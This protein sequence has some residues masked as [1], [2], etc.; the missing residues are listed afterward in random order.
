MHHEHLPARQP[1]HQ[2]AGGSGQASSASAAREKGDD[3][4]LIEETGRARNDR[5]QYIEKAGQHFA[6]Q[7]TYKER[8]YHEGNQRSTRISKYQR[9]PE[10]SHLQEPTQPA[11]KEKCI[12]KGNAGQSTHCIRGID[13]SS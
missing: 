1:Y 8:T 7:D 10:Q 11:T 12:V 2:P 9:R 3:F 5:S 13:R 6:K 4:I